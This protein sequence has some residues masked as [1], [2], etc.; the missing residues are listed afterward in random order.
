MTRFA[1]AAVAFLIGTTVAADDVSLAALAGSY[2]AVSASHHGKAVPADVLAGF[3]AKIEKDDLTF[4]VKGKDYPAKLK[5]DAKSTPAHLDLAPQDGPDKGR[6]FPGIVRL[7]KGEVVL[8][9]TE[10]ADRPADFA[11]GKDVMVVR[12]KRD[13]G[14]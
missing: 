2:K 6:T 7:E 3:A 13:G 4:S 11:G 10:T 5:L 1:L 9:F 14:K 12:L 8:A